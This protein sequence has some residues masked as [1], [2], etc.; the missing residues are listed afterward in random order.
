MAKKILLVD[1]DL[2]IREAYQAM[3]QSEGFEVDVAVDGLQGYEK[4]KTNTYDLVL[5]DVMLPKLD[6]IGILT[7]LEEDKVKLRGGPI[8][9]LT[10]LAHDPV[11]KESLSKGAKAYLIKT[12]LTPEQLVAKVREFTGEKP[13]ATNATA[14]TAD[15]T[16]KVAASANAATTAT[17]KATAAPKVAA[18]PPATPHAAAPVVPASPASTPPTAPTTK[19][20]PTKIKTN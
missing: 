2:F 20:T 15:A 7:K 10:N 8:V 4:I 1:D 18:A 3:F 5:L 14:A 16:P 11:L 9:L 12:D 6:G 13:A 19:P 17:P